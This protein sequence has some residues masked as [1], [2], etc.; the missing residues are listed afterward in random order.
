MMCA[1][2]LLQSADPAANL[3]SAY[4][5]TPAS[6]NILICI[7]VMDKRRLRLKPQILEKLVFIYC[8][9]RIKKKISEENLHTSFENKI[10]LRHDLPC[11][12]KR[13]RELSR[14]KDNWSTQYSLNYDLLV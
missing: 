3:A 11:M 9:K 14:K 2:L 5:S 7:N 4:T 6:V 8:N 1:S 12:G 13:H 10:Q